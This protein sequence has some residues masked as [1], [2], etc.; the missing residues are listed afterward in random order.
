[1][2]KVRQYASLGYAVA[3]I[4]FNTHGCRANS[5]APAGF[6]VAANSI[7]LH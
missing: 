6:S 2:Q 7:Q 1:M 4:Q 5:H 3:G